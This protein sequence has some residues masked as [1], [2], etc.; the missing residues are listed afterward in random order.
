[1]APITPTGPYPPT[2]IVEPVDRDKVIEWDHWTNKLIELTAKLRETPINQLFDYRPI[3]AILDKLEVLEPEVLKK[4]ETVEIESL[5]TFMF[6]V[7]ILED[8]KVT[9]RK[10]KKLPVPLLDF[11]RGYEEVYGAL[12]E[13]KK[14]EEE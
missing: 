6:T 1:M 3:K 4:K 9:G 11:I 8:A 7:K 14:K 12:S 5:R 13:E 2:S 10:L